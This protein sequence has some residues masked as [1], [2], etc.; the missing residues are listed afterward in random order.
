ML[1]ESRKGTQMQINPISNQIQNSFGAVQSDYYGVKRINGAGL[2][3]AYDP[4]H[5]F[6]YLVFRCR[7]VAPSLIK[8]KIDELNDEGKSNYN[9]GRAIMPFTHKDLKK[10]ATL[11]NSITDVYSSCRGDIK[12]AQELWNIHRIM[13]KSNL[14]LLA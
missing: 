6:S 9:E 11:K 5:T 1:G 14:Q 7:D 3:C 2:E 13:K 12:K 4:Q 10:Y 8:G